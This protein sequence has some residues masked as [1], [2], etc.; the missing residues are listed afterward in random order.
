MQSTYD[1][2]IGQE[3]NQG[4]VKQMDQFMVWGKLMKDPIAGMKSKVALDRF[5]TA[6]LLLS[7]Y[8]VGVA[9]ANG[10]T[11]EIDK[12]ENKLILE[13]LADADWNQ[14]GLDFRVTAARLFQQLGAKETDG[15]KAQP[16]KTTEEYHIAAKGW[17]REHST[18]FHITT[19]V[20]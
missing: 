13:T 19:A 10:K 15:W 5:T 8:N 4:F 18:S 20:R 2:A 16:W 7:K 1:Y 14:A 11:K 9:G 3:N 17:L 12:T 6:A